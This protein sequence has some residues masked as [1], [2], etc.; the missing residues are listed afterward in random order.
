MLHEH[1]GKSANLA[2]SLAVEARRDDGARARLVEEGMP[3]L[4][5]L[6]RRY[7]GR[8][9]D[10]DDLLQEAV[11]G[12]LR[13]VERYEPS[14]G[15]FAAWAVLWVRQALQ[16]AVAE[17]S[18]AVRLPTHVLWDMHELKDAR[19][20]LSQASGRE[21]SLR[22][23]ADELG[24][25]L[26]R[27]GE[28]LRAERPADSTEGMDL[29]DDPLGEQQFED[30][31]LRLTADQ[32]RPSLLRLTAREREVLRLR[33]EGESL[34]TIGRRLGISGERVRAIEGRALARLRTSA[35]SGVDTSRRLLTPPVEPTPKGGTQ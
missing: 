20:R 2:D 23:L 11:V 7:A 34:R 28:V 15:P 3:L 8:G 30:V 10:T 31:L 29:L 1:A 18:R 14:R 4:R 33:A 13:A 24:W 17:C 19:E 5:R 32:L 22:S 9:V 27:V 12:L 26:D 35:T 21:P 25:S 6:V 16:Q